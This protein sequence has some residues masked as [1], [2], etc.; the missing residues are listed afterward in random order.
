MAT[1]RKNHRFPEPPGDIGS[2]PGFR[3]VRRNGSKA[4]Q[5]ARIYIQDLHTDFH[6]KLSPRNIE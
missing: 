4:A 2:I 6:S 5:L 1:P 3:L